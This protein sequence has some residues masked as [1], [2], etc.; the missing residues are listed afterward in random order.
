M[1]L[2]TRDALLVILLKF[3]THWI[4]SALS[5]T[6]WTLYTRNYEIPRN[7]QQLCL[8]N[9]E[10]QTD[11][12]QIHRPGS[13]CKQK[14]NCQG[15]KVWGVLTQQ[16]LTIKLHR[17][18]PGLSRTSWETTWAQERTLSVWAPGRSD[19]QQP[20]GPRA[21]RGTQ[22]EKTHT[23][24]E[25]SH[26]LH[27]GSMCSSLPALN[28]SRLEEHRI[29]SRKQRWQGQGPPIQIQTQEQGNQGETETSRKQF[30]S[31]SLFWLQAREGT[32]RD[33]RKGLE[34]AEAG[35][36]SQSPTGDR[37]GSQT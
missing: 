6:Q 1:W 5:C 33:W 24:S 17:L 14:K 9:H 4:I 18:S 29:W 10:V 15:D 21:W 23:V 37:A 31:G 32:H 28:W 13:H 8:R 7:A 36:C 25:I 3:K 11:A 22:A 19:K 16:L 30:T 20:C 34:W 26:L 12:G 35:L 2:T 27:T